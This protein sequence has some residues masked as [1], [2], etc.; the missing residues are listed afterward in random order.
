[1]CVHFNCAQPIK[2]ACMHSNGAYTQNAPP[3]PPP[4]PKVAAEPT[5]LVPNKFSPLQNSMSATV[6]CTLAFQA[7]TAD[8]DMFP[9]TARYFAQLSND[10][11]GGA[12]SPTIFPST[13]QSLRTNCAQNNRGAD[14]AQFP[15][16]SLAKSPG[17]PAKRRPA[18]KRAHKMNADFAELVVQRFDS[19]LTGMGELAEKLGHLTESRVRVEK[20]KARNEG[21]RG[22]EGGGEG[23]VETKLNAL[24]AEGE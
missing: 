11:N 10:G 5:A 19:V 9:H 15:S 20:G 22:G 1:M 21:E 14:G 3:P 2:E 7:S 16:S 18:G 12:A 8:V 17:H 24:A 23:D 13:P 6:P 4:T